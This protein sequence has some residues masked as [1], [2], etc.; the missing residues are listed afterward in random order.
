MT[1]VHAARMLGLGLGVVLMGGC[2]ELDHSLLR[3]ETATAMAASP[4]SKT[5]ASKTPAAGIAIHHHRP[6]SP[7]YHELH[8]LLQETGVLEE[9]A[10]AVSPA[11]TQFGT[12]SIPVHVQACGDETS[13]YDPIAQEITLC[14]E[15]ADAYRRMFKNRHVP[16]EES[17]GNSLD[18]MTLTLHHHVGQA[19]ADRLNRVSESPMDPSLLTTALMILHG[20]E[21][22]LSILPALLVFTAPNDSAT[23][24]LQSSLR[25]A[26]V[27]ADHPLDARRLQSALC[28]IY[29]SRPDDFD[30]LRQDGLLS[31]SQSTA[32]R[33]NFPAERAYW[34]QVF[35]ASRLPAGSPPRPEPTP[36][37]PA[38]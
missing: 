19:L 23:R 14:Y 34:Q 8:H 29:G 11:L 1:I 9:V 30:F 18:A 5:P 2:V 17:L 35:A 22:E 27:D 26:G 31:E 36:P 33:Q 38:E 6:P 25:Q 3:L 4:A 13:F 16:D 24:I 15:L 20:Q 37:V 7:E 21:G 10:N 28:L 12:M 32:C